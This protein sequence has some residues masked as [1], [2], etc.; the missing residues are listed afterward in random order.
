MV[1]SK[2]FIM[3]TLYVILAIIVLFNFNLYHRIGVGWGKAI[4][5]AAAEEMTEDMENTTVDVP[6][7]SQ[8]SPPNDELDNHTSPLSQ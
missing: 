5:K 1:K 7:E 6:Q 2:F 8:E 3:V 4:S